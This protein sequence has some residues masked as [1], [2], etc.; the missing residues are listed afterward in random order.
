M[1]FEKNVLIV[2][3]IVEKSVLGTKKIGNRRAEKIGVS[4]SSSSSSQNRAS[5]DAKHFFRVAGK[6]SVSTVETDLEQMLPFRSTIGSSP[7]TEG[8]KKAFSSSKFRMGENGVASHAT[9]G[10]GGGGNNFLTSFSLLS[11]M[12]I[13]L[14]RDETFWFPVLRKRFRRR[15]IFTVFL[16]PLLFLLCFKTYRWQKKILFFQA[17]LFQGSM[18]KEKKIL[19]R[20]R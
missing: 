16:F 3:I 7:F 2:I 14:R 4:S 1:C 8:L 20:N 6:G 12:H 9:D 18:Q 5:K 10:G 19:I 11:W 17:T 13:H 15:F